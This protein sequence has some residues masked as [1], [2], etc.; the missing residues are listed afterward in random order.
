MEQGLELFHKDLQEMCYQCKDFYGHHWI[1]SV[2][3]E[4]S[5]TRQ[6]THETL[7]MASQDSLEVPHA[8]EFSD[9]LDS[10]NETT[11]GMVVKPSKRTWRTILTPQGKQRFDLY[12]C[13]KHKLGRTFKSRFHRR[14]MFSGRETTTINVLELKAVILALQHFSRRCSKKQVLVA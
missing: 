6:D 7:S 13:I 14:F 9:S 11:H 8:S 5:E 4:N 10:G 1:T 2:Y 3:R 12:R